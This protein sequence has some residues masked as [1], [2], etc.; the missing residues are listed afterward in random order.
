MFEKA[1]WV[2]FPIDNIDIANKYN[3]V[4]YLAK[5]FGVKNGLRNAI[6]H[7]CGLGEAAYFVNGE[8]IPDSYRPTI[9]CTPTKTVVYNE[10]DIT[11][12]LHEGLNRLG[13][14]LSVNREHSLI[15]K[16]TPSAIVQLTLE[17]DD[18][19]L[20]TIVSNSSFKGNISPIVFNFWTCGE[21]YDANNEIPDWCDCDFDDSGWS[22]VTELPNMECLFRTSDCP[23]IRKISEKAGKEIAPKLFDFGIT[24]AGYVR[25]RVTGKKG[26]RIKLNYS[27]RLMPD[28]QHIDGSAYMKEEKLCPSMYN[29]DEYVLDGTKNKVFDQY[30]SIHG[31]RYVE[32]VGEYEDIL[33]TAVTCHTDMKK[34]SSFKCNN[35]ML[36]KIHDACVNSILTCLQTFFVDNPKRDMAWV[37][38]QMLSAESTA[39][40]FDCYRVYYE[41]MMMCRDAMRDDGL[42]PW[43]VPA[44]HGEC[45]YENRFLGPDW[46]GGVIIQ[47]PYY[48]YK[49]TNRAEM[50]ETM[51]G[52]MDKSLVFFAT[53]SKNGNF[54][55]NKSGTGD[56]SAV[57]DGCPLEVAMTVWYRINVLCMLEMAEALGKDTCKYRKLAENIKVE[58]RNKYVANGKIIGLHISEFILPVYGGILEKDEIPAALEQIVCMIKADNMAFTFGVHGLRMIFDI[59]STG[60]YAQIVY[61]VLINDKV[62]GY[63]RN[64]TLGYDTVPERFDWEKNGIFSLN[65]HFFSMV[66]AWFYKWVAGI[67]MN[68]FGYSDVIISPVKIKGIDSFNAEHHG[69]NVCLKDAVITVNSPYAFTLKLNGIC[70]KFSKGEYCFPVDYAIY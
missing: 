22:D 28:G 3:P 65:H 37:G 46:S 24:T 62:L 40:I 42:L 55:L 1:K 11:A 12:L 25:V 41:N 7:I 56:W 18:T 52:L 23:P 43:I 57:K 53:L 20:E 33:L 45:N 36:N 49:Y 34:L 27:E 64:I 63:A 14:M 60:G 32:V 8:S 70:K 66:A 67:Q 10:Y 16:R 15:H 58:Y 48:I 30:F 5:S 50:A 54:L 26:S 21:I 19:T 9:P 44:I 61:D 51:W 39:I 68:G 13:I 38:D 31:F 2:Q 29:S 69:I 59:L 6:L 35:M 4:P 17:Y 47:V